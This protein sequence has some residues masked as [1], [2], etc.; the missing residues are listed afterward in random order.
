MS[1]RYIRAESVGAVLILLMLAVGAGCDGGAEN[2]PE[3]DPIVGS[4]Q[5]VT[6][7]MY[8]TPVG[9]LT[10][11]AAQFLAMSG[12]GAAESVLEFRQD[13]GTD[14]T[15]TVTTTYDD[16]SQDTMDGTWTA[17]GTELT[18]VGAGIDGTV[19]YRIEEDTTLTLTRTMPISF[20]PNT[21]EEDIV[22]DMVYN[23]VVN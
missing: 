12:T 17:E 14:G 11:P 4:W 23:R 15:A 13:D 21:P 16:N 1:W 9:I 3:P 19:T 2:L 8:D 10:G 20:V 18:V 7:V 22:L 6:I 5:M